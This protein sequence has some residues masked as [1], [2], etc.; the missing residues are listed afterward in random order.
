M[1]MLMPDADADADADALVIVIIAI[2]VKLYIQY[3]VYTLIFIIHAI[4]ISSILLKK[5]CNRNVYYSA[6]NTHTH[7]ISKAQQD[8]LETAD[9]RNKERE[10]GS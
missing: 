5:E 7:I 8:W 10:S 4:A 9:W 6:S 1:L 3:H 2:I